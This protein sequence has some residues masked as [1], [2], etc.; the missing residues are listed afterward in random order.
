MYSQ[1]QKPIPIRSNFSNANDR[2]IIEWRNISF[3]IHQSDDLFTLPA[4]WLDVL[5]ILAGMWYGRVNICGYEW[6]RIDLL[7]QVCKCVVDLSV[8]CLI[9]SD[10]E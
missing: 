9:C 5:D 1:R 10:V 7:L 6:I 4:R 3:M 8:F 2:G